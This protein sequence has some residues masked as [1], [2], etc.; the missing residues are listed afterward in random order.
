MKIAD[1]SITGSLGSAPAFTVD[2]DLTD[3]SF[4]GC[5]EEEMARIESSQTSRDAQEE[6]LF[7]DDIASIKENGLV[8]YIMELHQERLREEILASMGLTEEDLAKM[9]PEQRAA[10]EKAI[11]EEIRKRMAAEAMME[12]KDGDKSDSSK[13]EEM[14]MPICPVSILESGE[15]DTNELSAKRQENQEE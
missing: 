3:G 8:D 15:L 7:A 2:N 14:M 5:L 4:S 9:P 12:K 6:E 13:L 10:I 1:Y 11:A